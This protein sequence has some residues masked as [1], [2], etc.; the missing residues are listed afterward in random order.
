MAYLAVDRNNQE[1]MFDGKPIYDR[2]EDCWVEDDGDELVYND[3][4]DFSA[5]VHW[6]D[7][8]FYGIELPKGTI[9]K[10]LGKELTFRDDPVEI[11]YED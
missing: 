5:G 7:K 10:I 3:Y 1:L 8:V 6:E 11:R 9:E 4:A 2:I